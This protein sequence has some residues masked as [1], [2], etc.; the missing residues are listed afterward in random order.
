MIGDF[1]VL[2]HSVCSLQPKTRARKSISLVTCIYDEIIKSQKVDFIGHENQIGTE[3]VQ[4]TPDQVKVAD[5]SKVNIAVYKSNET[6][7]VV[8]RIETEAAV[9]NQRV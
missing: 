8:V 9:D 5:Q 2:G 6:R 1:P 4:F 7:A 3:I